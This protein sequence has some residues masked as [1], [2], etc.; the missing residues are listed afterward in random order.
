M[1]YVVKFTPKG[2]REFEVPSILTVSW[3][4][5]RSTAPTGQSAQNFH[6]IET[7]IVARQKSL[8]RNGKVSNET[9]TV[10]LA[11]AVGN[12]AYF[13]GSIVVTSPDD[14]SITI[15]TVRWDEGQICGIK[16]AGSP[17][18]M[19]ETLSIAVSGL[20]VDDVEFKTGY[21]S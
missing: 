9:E 13:S 10:K 21:G 18:G 14:E 7:I 11:A 16:Y 3:G 12:K 15:Q 2:S 8:K 1:S 6:N 20:K 5:G 19:V 17:H 4:A